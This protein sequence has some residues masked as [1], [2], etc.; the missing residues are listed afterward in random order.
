MN[1]K[2][3]AGCLIASALMLPIAA[4]AIDSGEADRSSKMGAVKEVVKDTAITTKVKADLAEEKVS[5]LVSVSVDTD[6][7]GMV[8]LSGT[9]AN[10]AAVNK[11]VSIAGAVKGVTSVE[12]H[13]KISADK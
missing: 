2:L 9:A 12:N 13:I 3:A 1:I 4:H 7:K 5:S 8:T 10:Q 6:S 11:A